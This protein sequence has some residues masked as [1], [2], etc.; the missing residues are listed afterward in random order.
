M[1]RIAL[2]E[3]IVTKVERA[4]H[5]VR[6]L[7]QMCQIYDESRPI[8]L[9]A[10]RLPTSDIPGNDIWGVRARVVKQPPREVAAVAGDIA[11]NLRSSLEYLARAL[12]V[13]NGGEPIDTGRQKTQFPIVNWSDLTK[14]TIHGGVEAEAM[15]VVRSVQPGPD[16]AS[17]RHPLAVLGALNNEDKHHAPLVTAG[18]T[19]SPAAFIIRTVEADPVG[20]ISPLARWLR[21]GEW[22]VKPCFPLPADAEVVVESTISSVVTLEGD[23]LTMPSIVNDFDYLLRF[24]RGVL[25][26]KFRRFFDEPWPDDVFIPEGPVPAIVEAKAKALDTATVL[27]AAERLGADFPFSSDGTQHILLLGVAEYFNVDPEL[28]LPTE[29]G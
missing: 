12:V 11:H 20:I 9:V 18:G 17:S 4:E 21:D 10:E 7:D 23:S 1:S 19:A 6:E 2:P 14:L 27:R 28:M 13:T 29:N 26:P 8:E 16:G 24:V 3:S 25:L 15:D 22:A 5:L